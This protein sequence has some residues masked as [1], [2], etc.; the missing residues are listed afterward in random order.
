MERIKVLIVED[1]QMIAD[2]I[3]FR[4]TKNELEVV[5]ICRSGEEAIDMVQKKKPDLILMDIALAGE[6]DGITTAE[7]IHQQQFIPIIYL[8]DYTDV[9]TIDRAKKTLPANYL[10]KPFNEPDLIRAIDIAF[11]NARHAPAAQNRSKDHVFLRTSNQVFVK[12]P[13]ADI[14]YL[15]ADRA[16]CN[17][18]TTTKN[19]T[20]S[21]SMNH[22]FEQF[23][24][25]DF[26]KVHRSYV[27]NIKKITALDGNVIHFDE[28]EVTMSKEYRDDVIR[29]L[30]II[31]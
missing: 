6:M 4:L 25:E 20:L 27:V 9:R 26:I 1:L 29:L 8:S 28:R 11:A 19:Y 13:V 24:H 18:M 3:A 5:G 15:E 2:D 14:L 7:R 30:K 22:V 23:D 16:Y 21:T 10:A 31:R 12:L 17:V